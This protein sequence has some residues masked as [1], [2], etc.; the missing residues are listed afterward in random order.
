MS[1]EIPLFPLGMV[2]FPG[3]RVSLHIFED[4]YK[5]MITECLESDTE[6]GLMW[7]S[8]DEFKQVGCAVRV[9]DVI[10]QFADG[11]MNI[12]IEGTDRIRLIERK[13]D[14]AYISGIVERIGDDVDP[15]AK[16]LIKET[17]AL[18]VEALKLSIGWYR[19]PAQDDESVGLLTYTI[20]S[21]LGMPV[22]RQ[23]IL[24][25]QTSITG[26]F[27]LLRE[28]LERTLGGLREHARKIGGNGKVNR[29][30]T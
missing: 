8:D 15:P 3:C 6:F 28:M 18:Y 4:R 22:D 13:D 12:I 1:E 26:R 25:E 14:K 7:G 2:I 17:R 19:A 16:T 30:K 20:A 9:T 10:N 29:G 21:A 5:L 27:R 23:Q 24:L 11:R